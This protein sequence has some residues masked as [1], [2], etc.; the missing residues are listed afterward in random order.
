MLSH[1]YFL[2]LLILI[3][4]IEILAAPILTYP[5]GRDQGEFATIGAAILN[6]RVP[7]ID[8]W[9]PKPPAVFYVYAQVTRWLGVSAWAI[10]AIDLL[11]FPLIAVGLYWI[12]RRLSNHITALFGVA[13]FA[14]LYFT[15]SFWTLSQNDGIALVPMVGMTAL[16]LH[17]T[18][19]EERHWLSMLLA[20]MLGGVTL[21]FKYPFALIISGIYGAYLLMTFRRGWRTVLVGT[22]A[23]TTGGLIVTGGGALYLDSKGAFD[24]LVESAEVTSDYTQQ[25][26][27]LDDFLNAPTWRQ[28]RTDR[29]THWRGLIALWAVTTILLM[30]QRDKKPAMNGQVL[31]WLWLVGATAAMLVQ[32]KGYDYHWLPM[33]PPMVLLV[34]VNAALILERLPQHRLIAAGIMAVVLADMI[35][36]LWL[37]ALDYMLGDEDQQAYYSTFRGGEFVAD[38]SQAVVDYLKA[39]T[40]PGESL[41]I[42]GFRPEVYYLTEL[43]PATRFIFQFPLV[44]QW[45]PREW[46]DENVQRLWG[47]KP[48]YVL[49]LQVD[50]MPWVTGRDEDSNQLLQEYTELNN[51]LICNYDRDTQIGNFFIWTRKSENCLGESL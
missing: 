1:K 3:L 27:N 36:R 23:F 15:E 34:T 10:R 29:W 20:G 30:I 26:Y 43:Q 28:A 40:S 48:R 21:W 33:L 39:R 37:P 2:S 6:G 31:L 18:T 7:Y 9:N 17:S 47:N 32:A 41:Y 49:I 4:L 46:Q 50:Y 16:V 19:A 35:A 45:Y 25:S 44:A 42:W 12:G 24:A 8:I 22:A 11:I 14:S 5:L 51:W 13:A 38:E